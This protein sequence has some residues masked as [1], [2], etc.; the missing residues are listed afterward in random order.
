MAE[1]DEDE[2]NYVIAEAIK[3]IEIRVH[4]ATLIMTEEKRRLEAGEPFD[5]TDD[6]TWVDCRFSRITLLL[7]EKLKDRKLKKVFL[8]KF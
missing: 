1:S 7:A 8:D 3:R 6:E 2:L 4:L 5:I